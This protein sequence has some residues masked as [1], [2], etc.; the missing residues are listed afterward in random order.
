MYEAGYRGH[1]VNTVTDTFAANRS[2]TA[3][4]MAAI[5]VMAG[6]FLDW[7]DGAV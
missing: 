3:L 7:A 5:P 4:I 1:L 2:A 6:A